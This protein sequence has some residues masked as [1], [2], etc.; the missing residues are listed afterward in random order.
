MRKKQ[1]AS[2]KLYFVSATSNL[3]TN[4]KMT[5]VLN[6]GIK[7]PAYLNRGV[8]RESKSITDYMFFLYNSARNH[9]SNI[10]FF[11]SNSHIK[12]RNSSER[13]ARNFG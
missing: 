9:K 5:I 10:R 3:L 7:R 2:S 1:I 4:F 12:G 8:S 6:P 13:K 11:F